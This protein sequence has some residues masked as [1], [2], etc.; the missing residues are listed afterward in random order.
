M[1]S[2]KPPFLE[3][4]RLVLFRDDTDS[5]TF[6]YVCL[7][8]SIVRNA[9][10]EPNLEA[11]AILPESGIGTETD[12]IMEAGLMLD[13]S[14]SVSQKELEAAEKAIK[15]KLGAKPRLLAP[16]PIHSGKVYLII[17]AAG[18][19]PDPKKWFVTSEVTPTIFGANT[20]SLVVRAVG[21]DAKLLI[22]A[23]DS[24]T[25]AA[26]VHY[27][28]KM[29]GIAPVFKA[30][31]N[32]HWS[33][34]YHHFEK[35]DKTNFI[36]FTDEITA[37]VDQLKE[38]SA[39]EIE[40][41]ELD[42]DIKSEAMKSLL[43]ELKSEVVKR[44][45]QPASSPLSASEKWEDRLAGGVS[46]VLS[47]IA[48]GVHHIR[49][50]IDE[51]QLSTTTINLSQRNV[52][53]YPLNPQALLPTLI[54]AAGG[55][56]DRIRWIKLDE[57]P[58]IDQKVEVRLSADTFKN[59][60]IKSVVIECRVVDAETEEIVVENSIVFDT[61][62]TLRNHLNFTRQKDR[63][64]R[65]DYRTTLF[66]TTDSLRLP[67]KLELDWL[68]ENSPYIYF[69]SAEY[70]E[71]RELTVGLDDTSL[72]GHAHLIEAQL[73]VLDK[74][75]LT[76]V[77][78]R[79][80]LFRSDDKAQ[81]VLSIVTNKTIPLRFDLNLTYFLAEAKEHKAS[82]TD[83]SSNFFFIPNPFENKWSVDLLCTADWT[84]TGKVILEARITDAEREDP[85]LLKFDFKSD[86]TEKTL[87]VATS[88]RT[89][90]EA[91]E[92]RV[93]VLTADGAVIQGPWQP[94]QGPVLVVSDRISAERIIRATLTHS[95]DFDR[96][97][98]KQVSVEFVYHDPANGIHL[99]SERLPFRR[100]GDTVEFRHP[101]PDFNRKG[102]Q[103]RSRVK[104]L[105]GEAYKS[106]W[107]DETRDKIEITIPDNLW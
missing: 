5:E 65:Y 79:T 68:S 19:E 75:D 102:F 31:M 20:A 42:P 51:S 97:S 4:G 94:H 107:F 2:Y 36:F 81:K 18:D 32:V 50:T 71:A 60:N 76:P 61:D 37:A 21:N 99:E 70:F 55:I 62:D 52:K 46:R 88:L 44:L 1:L 12:S 85:L 56:K 93:T 58:F 72:F 78:K 29:L 82:Y 53:T 13:V 40:V 26:G 11:Y 91:F 66:M 104:G 95:P 59:S 86:S 69:N 103:Y 33:K 100:I 98:I 49:R 27:E 35:F 74:N 92:Y 22:A 6:Y 57:I 84:K 28:L 87:G 64:Y 38:S 3:S 67:G 45:F 16:A 105:G 89:P 17:A 96:K 14:L 9:A 47:S 48:P 7:Q 41:Q 10:G 39:I 63:K 54:R 90:R 8:P 77:L 34:V 101:M 25:I 43:N 23:L 80:F 106:D 15:E 83:L 30:S 73:N 24:D